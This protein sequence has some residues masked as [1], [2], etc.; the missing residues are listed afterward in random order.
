MFTAK[1]QNESK[2]HKMANQSHFHVCAARKLLPKT[3]FAF[4]TGNEGTT[5]GTTGLHDIREDVYGRDT[6]TK[7]LISATFTFTLLE[8]CFRKTPLR[9]GTG[10]EGTTLVTT[11]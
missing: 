6:G 8:N 10:N 1:T 7:L 9:S 5:L 3:P 11:G 2:W 4:G